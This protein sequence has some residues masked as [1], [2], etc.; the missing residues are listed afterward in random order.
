MPCVYYFCQDPTDT[1]EQMEAKLIF[2]NAQFCLF[3]VPHDTNISDLLIISADHACHTSFWSVD[4][5]SDMEKIVEMWKAETLKREKWKAIGVKRLAFTPMRWY[6]EE[7]DAIKRMDW[8]TRI[9][10]T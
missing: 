6:I 1:V 8:T 3:F 5:E 2:E 7:E 10:M 4:D 9:W